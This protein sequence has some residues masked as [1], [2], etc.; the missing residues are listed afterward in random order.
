MTTS[1]KVAFLYDFV[2][3]SGA[4]PAGPLV[5]GTDGNFYGTTAYGGDANGDGVVFKITS[6]GKYTNLHTFDG[7]DGKT[8]TAGLVQASDGN[9][10]G[11]TSAGGTNGIGTL[12]KITTAG[13]FTK[14]VD[15]TTTDGSSPQVTL[16][17]HTNGILYG[18]AKSDGKNGLGTFY[19]Y[20]A[21]LPAFIRPVVN[22]GKV[23][24]KVGILGQGFTGTTA[25]TFN[26]VSASFSV[27]TDTYLTASVPSLATAGIVTVTTPTGKLSSL[28]TFIILPSVLSFSPTSGPVG[29]SVVI[30]GGGFTGASKVTFGVVKATTFTVNSASQITATVPTGAVTGKIA[31]TTSQGTATSSGTFT[32]TP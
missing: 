12:F 25:V 8:P 7:T 26:G 6:S 19:S 1:G 23:T 5:Q 13:V 22:Y 16:V 3:S 30:T 18:E 28:Q 9:L 17:Q 31:V 32:V 27:L 21:T 29:S 14:L 4:G 15:F 24:A 2:Q 11:V 10:Y 20:N